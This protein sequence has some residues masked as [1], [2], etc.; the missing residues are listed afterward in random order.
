MASARHLKPTII[1]VDNAEGAPNND[2]PSVGKTGHT[3]DRDIQRNQAASS[4]QKCTPL[5]VVCVP[6]PYVTAY[7]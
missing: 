6:S 5:C 7:S 1:Y 4:N 2:A 3:N